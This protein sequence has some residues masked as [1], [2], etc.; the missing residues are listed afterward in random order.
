MK[1]L[2]SINSDKIGLKRQAFILNTLSD[3]LETG[4]SV[5][6]SLKF[7]KTVSKPNAKIIT[8]I[9]SSLLDGY[10]LPEAM[11]F[12]LSKT[13]YQQLKIADNHGQ[14][15]AGLKE[16]AEFILEKMKQKNKIKELSFYPILLFT[17]L[18]SIILAIKIII[19]P[20]TS[21]KSSSET[22]GNLYG[23]IG[24]SLIVIIGTSLLIYKF[25]RFDRMKQVEWLI[26]IPL[27]G[28]IFF[29]YYQYYLAT[30][31]ALMLK[32]GLDMYKIVAVFKEFEESTFLQKIGQDIENGLNNGDNLERIFAKYPF[33]SD[34]MLVFLSNGS[35]NEKLA[36]NLNAW[37][38]MCFK[39]M[40]KAVEKIIKLI[41]PLSFVIIGIT[42]TV[43]Y[44]SLLMP[45]YQS[46]ENI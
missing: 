25:K 12:F 19:L 8:K 32:N 30:N 6:Q 31:L 41:Q 29:E 24:L 35:S 22:S 4:F 9:Q 44:L 38:K 1:T 40:T 28:K 39:R 42:I 10:S 18:F 46:M 11:K 5:Q 2:K 17:F 43:T 34:E 7:I 37:A 14:I 27:V 26:R 21:I 36:M 33:I 13:I 15:V 3:L 20:A 16:V 23:W 45:L